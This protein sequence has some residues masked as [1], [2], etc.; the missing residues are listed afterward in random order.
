MHPYAI[1]TTTT[2]KH[3][4]FIALTSALLLACG[5]STKTP[6]KGDL[7]PPEYEAA[8]TDLPYNIQFNKRAEYHYLDSQSE[9]RTIRL[10]YPD[11]QAEGNIAVV[12]VDSARL[13]PTIERSLRHLEINS[14]TAYTI[15]SDHP[16]GGLRHWLFVHPNGKNQMSWM[17]T[18]SS[19]MFLSGYIHLEAATD[20]TVDITPALTNIQTDITHLLNNLTVTTANK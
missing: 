19:T 9:Y 1:S 11:Y 15:E 10:S 5:G 6:M 16:E 2:M 13:I 14:D 12:M 20:S 7:Y 4:L 8:F 3:L 18:D 17:A